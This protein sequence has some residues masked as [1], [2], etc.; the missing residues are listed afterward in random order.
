MFTFL[1]L[2]VQRW[3]VAQD[4]QGILLH[5]ATQGPCLLLSQHPVTPPTLPGSD[6][7]HSPLSTV[8][9]KGVRKGRGVDSQLP[10]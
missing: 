4:R 9:R 3:L 8:Q 2:T 1:D 5:T 10:C 7:A 6:L